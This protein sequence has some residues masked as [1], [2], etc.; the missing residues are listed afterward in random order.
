MK[1]AAGC[2]LHARLLPR[3]D[4]KIDAWPRRCSA[5]RESP[6]RVVGLDP[7]LAPFGAGKEICYV[8]P[9]YVTPAGIVDF[10][11]HQTVVGF[12][13]DRDS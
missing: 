12:D 11:A 10:P 7:Q 13:L 5:G 8:G 6:P 1:L 3:A 9:K 4:R 2:C